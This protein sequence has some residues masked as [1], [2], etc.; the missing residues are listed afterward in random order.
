V[1]ATNSNQVQ[2][3]VQQEE[4]SSAL[5]VK[6]YPSPASDVVNITLEDAMLDKQAVINLINSEGK[7]VQTRNSNGS[8]LVQ[9]NVAKQAPGYY[10]VSIESGGK[11]T[12]KSITIVR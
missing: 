10:I 5:E 2:R 6:V 11:K 4:K 1:P 12:N 8:R 9:L 7:I 3:A